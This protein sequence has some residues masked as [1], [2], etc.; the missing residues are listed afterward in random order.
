MRIVAGDM[1]I[2]NTTLLGGGDFVT[3]YRE[4]TLTSPLNKGKFSTSD[5]G[6]VVHVP[7]TAALCVY[8]VC[9]EVTG[10]I[11]GAYLTVVS[12]ARINKW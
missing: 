8:V 11:L 2:A 1:V 4:S 12:S 6:L 5:M 7:D 9:P 10:W 3:V